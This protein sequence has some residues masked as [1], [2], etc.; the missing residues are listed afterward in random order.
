[1]KFSLSTY[2]NAKKN[3]KLSFGVR[4]NT[5]T[6]FE[7]DNFV[8]R[9]S[10]I[11]NS[12]LGFR[13]YIGA[14]TN[15]SNCKIGR[16]C[17]I[18]SNIS[19]INGFH[20]VSECVSTHP[21]FYS[22]N[23]AGFESY[24][25]T[26]KYNEYKFVDEEYYAVIGNDVWIGNHAIIMA[27]VRVGDGAIIAAGA[28][29]TKDVPDF[30]IVGGVPAKVIKKRF[31]DDD[32]KRIKETNWWNRRKEWLRNKADCFESIESFLEQLGAGISDE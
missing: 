12:Y 23:A 10:R 28:V 29:V 25:R 17:S 7:G 22:L 19:I 20:P 3:A 14:E 9:R 18:G 24:V 30:A 16:Y 32:I 8:G 6:F 4:Y 11:E 21:A 26:Q 1:M 31:A 13:S 27:G 15:I 5:G 2:L